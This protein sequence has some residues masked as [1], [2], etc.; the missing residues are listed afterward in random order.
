MEVSALVLILDTKV[1]DGNLVVHNFEVVLACEPDS[2]VGQ[3]LIR[4]D[5][6]ELPVQLPF[7]FVVE[8]NTADLPPG[9]V[10]FFGHFVIEAIE[11]SIMT[12]FFSFDEAVIN[13]LSIWSQILS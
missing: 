13:R 8:D 12:G 9:A 5:L 4:I 7:E 2:L 1:G 6:R 11:V 10:N 3:F